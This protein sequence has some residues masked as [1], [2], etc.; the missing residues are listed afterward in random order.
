VYGLTQGVIAVAAGGFHTCAMTNTQV[1]C[2]GDNTY[3]QLGN[4][5]RISSKY[6]VAVIGI[7]HP[8]VS[9]TVGTNHTCAVLDNG[10]I[11][12]WGYNRNG[13]LGDGERED[14]TTA[15]LVEG[16]DGIDF[17]EVSA[18]DR[19]SCALSTAGKAYCWGFN[20]DGQLGNGTNINSD[21]P[22]S[23]SGLDQ[24]AVD[25]ALGIAHTCALMQDMTLRCWGNNLYGQL[26]DG[27]TYE[28]WLPVVTRGLG[29]SATDLTAGGY[30]SCARLSNADAVQCWGYNQSGQLGDG[31]TFTRLLPVTVQGLNAASFAA[32]TQTTCAV[33]STNSLAGAGRVNCWGDNTRGQIGNNS[34]PWSLVPLPVNALVLAQ[35]EINYPT[36]YPG[37]FFTITGKNFT[38]NTSVK[39]LI[40]N[41][42]LSSSLMTDALGETAFVM[43]T[44]SA[45]SG[46]YV[47]TV[48]AGK[49]Q[50]I[51]FH[52]EWEA[53]THAQEDDEPVFYVP[54]GIALTWTGFLPWSAK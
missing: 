32:G 9:L 44:S 25:I 12:C 34:L 22:V 15:T 39:L 38:A 46:G 42:P 14:S 16:V 19:H 52:L 1:F 17:S 41:L 36:G 28:H 13:Q 30:Q 24:K 37:S 3:G 53:E 5:T 51:S 47:V 50:N 40:N 26:G 31:T 10:V 4:G 49:T 20:G 18:G 35:L 33:T 23:V 54:G 45:D 7:T 8:P 2:W 48:Q 29:G 6:P 43:D 21:L 27:T 11:K